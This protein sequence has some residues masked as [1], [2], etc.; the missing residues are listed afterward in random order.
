MTTQTTNHQRE[1]EL[2]P[3]V[4]VI[5]MFILMGLALA[6][7]G[8]ARLIDAPLAGAVVKAPVAAERSVR[9]IGGRDGAVEVRGADN[10]LIAHSSEEKNGFIGVVWRVLARDRA[11]HGVPDTAPIRVLRRQNGHIAIEDTATD[12][13][14]ELIGYGADNVAA[15]ARL[16]D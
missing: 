8:F 2:V 7:A 5:A 12:W 6:I 3:R 1:P 16:V 14:I 13:S 15:F 9:L 11:T 4:M 10:A